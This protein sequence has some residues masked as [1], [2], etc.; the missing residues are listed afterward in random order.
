MFWDKFKKNKEQKNEAAQEAPKAPASEFVYGVEETFKLKEGDDLIVVGRVKGTVRTGDAVYVSNPGNEEDGDIFLTTIK[1]MNINNNPVDE[2]TDCLVALRLENGLKSGLIK[3]GS[4]AHSRG[5]SAKDVHDAYVGSLGVVYVGL[6]K[7]DLSDEDLKDLSA[8]KLGD[9]YNAFLVSTSSDPE[10]R[11]PFKE[12]IDRMMKALCE[13]L[14]A[15]KEIYVVY[16]ERTGEPHM[17]V[18]AS[19][20]ENGDYM[21][22][23]PDIMVISKAYYPVFKDIYSQKGCELKLISN[24]EDGKGIYRELGRAFY[25]NGAC[26]VRFNTP[27]YAIGNTMLVDKPDFSDQPEINIPVSNPDLVRWMLLMGQMEEFDTEDKKT[28]Y[29][30]YY[31]FL[32]QEISNAKFLIPISGDLPKGDENGKAVL[33]KDTKISFPIRD[34]KDGRQTI[35]VFTDW[36]RLRKVFDEKWGGMV[37]TLDGMIEVF[38]YSIN[39]SDHPAEGIYF[40]KTAYDLLKNRENK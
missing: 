33:E 20:Q 31:N 3:T 22:S 1:S 7:L 17:F 5:A 36:Y 9:I 30:I 32:N 38:D 4:V 16:N 11:V 23:T 2:A 15:S 8:T 24:G 40:S 12:K 35:C 21:V 37:Q 27:G 19:R 18:K 39:A 34:G 29:K 14:L 10:K 28:I 6:K 26:G 13:K 25:I